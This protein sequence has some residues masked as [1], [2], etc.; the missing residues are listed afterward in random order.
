MGLD[1]YGHEVGFNLAGQ[2][3]VKSIPGLFVS[4]VLL[5]VLFLYGYVRFEYLIYRKNPLIT[6]S[7]LFDFFDSSEVVNF[8]EIGFKVAF[9]VE[10]YDANREAKH[11]PNYVRWV[12]QMTEIV[13]GEEVGQ[14]LTFHTCTEEDFDAFPPPGPSFKKQYDAHRARKNLQCLDEGQTI[15]VFGEGDYTDLRRLDLLFLPCLPDVQN[16]ICLTSLQDK[17]DYLGSVDFVLMHTNQKFDPTELFAN[18][19]STETVFKNM[20][21]D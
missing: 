8:D 17:I 6:R 9:A 1:L 19:V 16:G 15:E 7:E 11:D 5:S 12:A 18:S 4:V 14:E 21:F 2:Q 10:Q 13:D 3:S 20:Q